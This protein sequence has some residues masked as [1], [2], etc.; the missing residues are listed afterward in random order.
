MAERDRYDWDRGRDLEDRDREYGRGRDRELNYDERGMMSRGADEVRSWFGDDEARRRREMDEQRQERFSS[1]ER[2]AGPNSQQVR[3]DHGWSNQRPDSRWQSEWGGSQSSYG[4]QRDFIGRSGDWG[5]RQYS[6]R[7][8][9]WDQPGY[10][11]ESTQWSGGPRD[12]GN[13]DTSRQYGNRWNMGRTDFSTTGEGR[14]SGQPSGSS[15]YGGWPYESGKFAGRGPRNYQRSDDR[16]REDVNERLT[17]DP[18]IDASDIDV[19]VQN[20][21]VTLS[22]TVDDRRTRRLAEEI[23][24]DLPGVRDVHVELKVN[25]SRWG[26]PGQYHQGGDQPRGREDGSIGPSD[27]QK[28][29]EGTTMNTKDVSKR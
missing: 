24:E 25:E 11:R 12:Y 6:P 10:R 1:R 7:G 17:A 29:D 4:D 22:G 16:V 27:L 14:W 2:D 28:R 18:R 13:E 3:H 23:I 26:R 20:G 19:R 15:S 8:R 5:R 21:E 9:E